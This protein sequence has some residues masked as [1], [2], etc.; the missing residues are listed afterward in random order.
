MNTHIIVFHD[1][2]TIKITAEQAKK[3][4]SNIE[5]RHFKA[6]LIGSSMI[7]F[8]AIAK[9]QPLEDYYRDYPD[10]RPLPVENFN[11]LPT[12]KK[13]FYER[14]KERYGAINGLIKGMEKF[15]QKQGGENNIKPATKELFKRIRQKFIN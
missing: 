11:Q 4:F 14:N 6:I 5:D 7:A 12:P 15:I 3:I 10:K 13:N 8:S 9:I 1:R 2:T